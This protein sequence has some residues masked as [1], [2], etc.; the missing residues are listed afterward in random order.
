[1]PQVIAGQAT[2]L[3][4]SVAKLT[5]DLIQNNW[6]TSNYSPLKPDIRFGLGTWDGY[7][8]IHIH[9]N[10]A[11]GESELYSLGGNYSK[12]R[13]PVSIN[14]YVRKNSDE[15][16]DTVGNVTRKVAEII[17]DNVANLG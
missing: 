13:D 17:K 1:M 16:P 9:I 2:D 14:V 4:E 11:E 12:V 15:I 10:P 6:P 7:R 8:D 5:K 3:T